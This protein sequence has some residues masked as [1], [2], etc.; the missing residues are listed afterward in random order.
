MATNRLLDHIISERKG[1]YCHTLEL[2]NYYEYENIIEQIVSDYKDDFTK[3]EIIDFFNNIDLYYYT[4][5]EPEYK[6]EEEQLYN[7]DVTRFVNDCY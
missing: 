4:G 1:H 6:E 3:D 7:F 5:D 2:A